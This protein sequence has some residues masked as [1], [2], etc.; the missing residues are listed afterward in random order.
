[1]PFGIVTG[2]PPQALSRRAESAP[3]KPYLNLAAYAILENGAA[4]YRR[5]KVP[6]KLD[7]AHLDREWSL[8]L[9][10]FQRQLDTMAGGLEERRLEFQRFDYSLRVSIQ[11]N[12]LSES[13]VK[14]LLKLSVEGVASRQSRGYVIYCPAV[15]EKETAIQFIANKEGWALRDIMAM[16]NENGDAGML[17]AVGHPRAPY[18]APQAVKNLV[19][20]RGGFVSRYPAGRAVHEFLT[21]LCSEA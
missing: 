18:N 2:L 3:L 14:E 15:A 5:G 19:R 6:L 17:N 7:P 8:K 16:G 9:A 12:R 4:I 11:E 20:K 13:Y 21:A 1:V 10:D